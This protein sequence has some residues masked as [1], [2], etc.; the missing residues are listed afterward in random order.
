MA[1]SRESALA[2]V[3][4]Y[5]DPDAGFRAETFIVLMVIAWNS[6]LQAML[7][8]ANVDY[9]G[10]DETGG[11]IVVGASEKVPATWDLVQLALGGDEYRAVRANREFFLKLRNQISHRYLPALDVAVAD[12]AQAMLLNDHSRP[13]ASASLSTSTGRAPDCADSGVSD[14][15]QVGSTAGPV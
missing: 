2:A 5:N 14:P 13:T 11:P 12:E 1:E 6:L 15:L 9:D 4:V 3:R 10:R 7:E 8:G